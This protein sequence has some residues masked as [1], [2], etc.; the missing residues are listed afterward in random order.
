MTMIKQKRVTM[1][2]NLYFLMYLKCVCFVNSKKKLNIV[3]QVTWYLFLF[4]IESVSI[5]V[6]MYTRLLN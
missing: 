6:Y 2:Q 5:H 3:L 4:S 1:K